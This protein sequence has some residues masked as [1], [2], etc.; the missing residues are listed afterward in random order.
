MYQQATKLKIAEVKP[1]FNKGDQLASQGKLP[2]NHQSLFCLPF[3]N[4]LKKNHTMTLSLLPGRN[5]LF[6]WN[7]AWF[8]LKVETQLQLSPNVWRIFSKNGKIEIIVWGFSSI[9]RRLS[10]ALT[11]LSIIENCNKVFGSDGLALIL[12]KKLLWWQMTESR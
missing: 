11:W 2:A 1:I 8:F 10:I 5:K 3:L 4:Y 9:S 12:I 6:L 7:P